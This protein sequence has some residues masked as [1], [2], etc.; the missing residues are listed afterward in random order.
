MSIEHFNQKI[1]G[2]LGIEL[3]DIAVVAIVIS[4]TLGGYFIGTLGSTHTE[5]SP[6]IITDSV[7]R[8]ENELARSAN[9]THGE[10]SV[11][12]SKNGTKYYYLGCSGANRIQE[13][14][15]V[16]FAS[17]REAEAAG[18]TLATNCTP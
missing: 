3:A 1:K 13:Q 4:C 6:V 9:S 15:K 17:G 14:N 18:Y 12:A 16:W 10:S 7:P 5:M 11:F 8:Y 2:S